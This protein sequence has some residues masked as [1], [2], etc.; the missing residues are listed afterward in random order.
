M[1]LSAESAVRVQGT[2]PV[3]D[4]HTLVSKQNNNQGKYYF[5]VLEYLKSKQLIE[6]IPVVVITGDDTPDTI[7]KAFAYP[8]LDVLNKP[9]KVENINR[10]LVS[11]KS[12]YE[13]N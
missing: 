13:K 2:Y 3:L 7:N 12:F 4:M 11:I 8:I 9:F 5:E 6:K 1:I 10:V